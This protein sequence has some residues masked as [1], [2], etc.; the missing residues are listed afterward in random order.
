MNGKPKVSLA[1]LKGKVVIVDFW[2]TWCST[3][4]VEMPSLERL[5]ADLR[6]QNKPVT[7][8]GIAAR[9]G[10]KLNIPGFEQIVQALKGE[11]ITLYGDGQDDDGGCACSHAPGPSPGPPG[12]MA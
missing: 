2:A 8:L 1:S 3:C 7:V 4:V 11:P 12:R 6:A 9:N 10:I 5:A